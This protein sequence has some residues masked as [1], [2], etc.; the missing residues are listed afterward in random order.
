MTWTRQPWASLTSAP[1]LP[2]T[3]QNTPGPAEQR[4]LVFSRMKLDSMHQDMTECFPSCRAESWRVLPRP[5]WPLCSALASPERQP[6]A[7]RVPALQSLPPELL[8]SVEIKAERDS[9][10][11]GP[12]LGSETD[13]SPGLAAWVLQ[14]HWLPRLWERVRKRKHRALAR[15]LAH[16]GCFQDARSHPLMS[17]L[18]SSPSF[19]PNRNRVYSTLIY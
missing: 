13:H 14:C 1:G 15:C 3:L 19:K 9:C 7:R 5:P 12:Q 6:R 10:V 8:F 2:H 4:T 17:S 11:S 18:S 16:S